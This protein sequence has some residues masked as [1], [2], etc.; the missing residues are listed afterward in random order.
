MSQINTI[1]FDFDGTVM[2][3][4]NVVLKSWQ[5]TFLTHEGKERP[6]QEIY[7]TFGEPLQ[8]SMGRIL[9]Q[10]P[11]EEAIA[12]YR[13]YHYHNFEELISLFPGIQELLEKLK[14]EMYKVGV[15]TSR[16]RPTTMKGIDKYNLAEYF[17]TIVT[18]DECTKHK[19]DPEP[20]LIALDKLGSL[21]EETLMIGDTVFDI[22]CAR[23]AGVK[24]VLVGWAKAM[25]QEEKTGPNAPDFIIEKPMDLLGIIQSMER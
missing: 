11:V 6:E 18:C 7:K 25:T 22:L 5:H 10:V 21:P 16:L 20:V 4:N 13:S 23:N 17:D 1:L 12:T 9:P 19:P 2:D 14:G 15:V 24:S 8:I 3:T